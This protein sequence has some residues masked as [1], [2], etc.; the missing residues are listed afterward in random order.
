MRWL[1]R[2]GHWAW[3]ALRS[4]MYLVFAAASVVSLYQASTA[5]GPTSDPDAELR[6][7]RSQLTEAKMRGQELGARV[8]AFDKRAEVRMQMIRAELGL[9]RPA[10]RVYL[11]K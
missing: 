4:V 9:L 1:R 3:T 8:D 7:L 2:M 10:E 5:P 6:H 11:L